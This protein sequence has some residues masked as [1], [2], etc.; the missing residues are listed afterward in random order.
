MGSMLD[1]MMDED[2]IKT[3][4]Q[5]P[6]QGRDG[7]PSG[8][9][10]NV[11][12]MHSDHFLKAMERSKEAVRKNPKTD[13]DKLKFDVQCALVA[14]WSF[15]EKCNAANIRKF[16]KGAPHVLEKIDTTAA[17]DSLFF[18]SAAKNSLNGQNL[19]SNSPKS[20]KV[21]TRQTAPI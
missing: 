8:E 15:D 4:I 11:R 1:Y 10:V 5:I 21:Q 18:I 13:I 14:S 7:K 17:N 19:K 20:R 9:T 2:A 16:L 6:V 12:S 3:G